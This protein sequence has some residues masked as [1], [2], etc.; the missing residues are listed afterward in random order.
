MQKSWEMLS[1]FKLY[2]HFKSTWIF[3]FV[4]PSLCVLSCVGYSWL[5]IKWRMIE[6]DQLSRDCGK[7]VTADCRFN[8]E[9]GKKIWIWHKNHTQLPHRPVVFW[10]FDYFWSLCAFKLCLTGYCTAFLTK[11]QSNQSA[12]DWL[13]SSTHINTSQTFL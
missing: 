9:G 13:H 6:E 2:V 7:I 3:I 11:S 8:R 10:L 5:H 12:P 1:I 4:H